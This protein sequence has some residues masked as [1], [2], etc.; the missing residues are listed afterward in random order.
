MYLKKLQLFN[1]KNHAEAS[2]AF[3]NEINCFT[4]PN[5]SGKT[6]VL[7]A[8][9]YLALCKS[10]FSGLDSQSIMEGSQ[11]FTIHGVFDINGV[12]E[13]IVCGL[14]QG[15]RK[16][17]K[18]NQKEYARLAEHI[19]LIPLVM[20]A[21]GDQELITGGSEERRKLIDSIICQVDKEY[22]ENLTTYQRILHQRNA[23]LKQM[24]AG[25]VSDAGTLELWDE[26]LAQSGE[27]I[28]ERRT[29]FHNEFQP[30][31]LRY[32][33]FIT[34]QL[35]AV[36]LTYISQLQH[37]NFVNL[38]KSH[39]SRDRIF[40]FTTAGIHKDDLHLNLNGKPVKRYGS[41]GQQKSFVVALKLAQFEYIT[42]ATGKKPLLLLDDIF[43]KL[44]DERMQKLLALVSEKDFGQLFVT[45]T[46]K[47]R[48][49]VVFGKLMKTVTAYHF[50]PQ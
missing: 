40:Q 39:S 29:T 14:K 24:A 15:Q 46:H 27:K 48:A 12:E 44:D 36:E 8:I 22:L 2:F 1:F 32:Y 43:E 20:I 5:G 28:F 4:G 35:E 34:N 45:D 30:L 17:V 3:N 37:D 19:G 42:N 18:R 23:L 6:N 41:Q 50:G 13:E 49:E 7:D 11:S 33:Q 26:Q 38:L 31:F 9:H 47:G 25:N 16:I 21:P 10:Y